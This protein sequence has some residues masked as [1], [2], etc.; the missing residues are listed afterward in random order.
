A[1]LDDVTRP[2]FLTRA[3]LGE[4]TYRGRLDPHHLI[5]DLAEHL[6]H[7]QVQ[8]LA[9]RGEQF[10]G[11]FFAASFDLGQISEPPPR[12][13][14]GRA[15]GSARPRPAAPHDLPDAPPEEYP[16]PPPPR[17]GSPAPAPAVRRVRRLCCVTPPRFVS[18]QRLE[19]AHRDTRVTPSIC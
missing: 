3:Q 12:R 2:R 10:R 17:S 14:R 9:D 5:A 16:R 7:R 11:R 1:D 15:T 4:R 13:R 19:G 18:G 8:S 6:G